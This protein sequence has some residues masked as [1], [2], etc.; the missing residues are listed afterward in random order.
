MQLTSVLAALLLSTSNI[1]SASL[2]AAL[3]VDTNAF[4][5]YAITKRAA[6]FDEHCGSKLKPSIITA[7]ITFANANRVGTTYDAS[8]VQGAFE[9]L[10]KFSN[11]DG[12]LRRK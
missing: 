9:A 6:I 11:T 5:N 3:P 10:Q 8:L 4:R 2:V 12:S 7:Q 1:V